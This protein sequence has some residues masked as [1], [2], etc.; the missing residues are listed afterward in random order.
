MRI[1]ALFS[2]VILVFIV[3]STITGYTGVSYRRGLHIHLEIKPVV[4]YS[5]GKAIISYKGL[6]DRVHQIYLP[7]SY[8]VP[9]IVFAIAL[10]PV[11]D[12]D[13]S[14]VY[15]NAV[16]LGVGGGLIKIPGPKPLCTINYVSYG[17]VERVAHHLEYTVLRWR[18]VSILLIKLYPHDIV[19]D[20][21]LRIYR[22]I[23]IW[24]DY[25][26][27][28]A[29]RIYLDSE[30][31]S[32]LNDIA[33]INLVDNI[34]INGDSDLILIITRP[35]FLDKLQPLVELREKQGF[36]VEVATVEDIVESG[37]SGRDIPE[38]M[39]NYVEQVYDESGGALKYLVLVGDVSGDKGYPN[40]PDDIGELEPWE[41]P[42]RYF[43]N[44][45]GTS[46]Y[47][48][49][50]YYT[51]SDWYYVTL[52]TTWDTNNN[53]IYG[54]PD[55][56]SDWAPEIAV[57]RLPFYSVDQLEDYVEALSNYSSLGIE[58]WL[59]TGSMLF[60]YNQDGWGDAGQ[61]GDTDS[62][63]VWA[64]VRYY[65]TV[66]GTRAVRLYEHYPV[67]TKI[68]SPDQY[69]GNI[70]TLTVSKTIY[71]LRPDIITWF[72][73][74]WPH[75]AWRVI[76][77]YDD[78]DGIPES[79][80]EIVRE[81]FLVTAN[82]TQQ[83]SRRAGII[84]AMSCLTA[85]YDANEELMD[86]WGMP[87]NMSLAE[88]YTATV[89]LWYMGWDRVTF[90]YIYTWSEQLNPDEWGLS[91]GL[92]YRAVKAM[93]RD[94]SA[95]KYDI[96]YSL[97]EAKIW[98]A[99]GG[100]SQSGRKVWWASTLFGDIS[101]LIGHANVYLDA[102]ITSNLTLRM[103]EKLNILVHMQTGRGEGLE[104]YTVKLLVNGVKVV[105]GVTNS[106]GYTVLSWVPN[107]PGRYT[108]TIK[109]DGT[110]ET[111][112]Y[113]LEY[114]VT[115]EANNM[116]VYPRQGPAN[117][118]IYLRANGYTPNSLVD[119][120]FNDTLVTTVYS[121]S[122]GD[123]DT[124]IRAPRLDPGYYVVQAVGREGGASRGFY[125]ITEPVVV[126]GLDDNILNITLE[127]LADDIYYIIY[128]DSI[129][130]AH[131]LTDTN[132]SARAIVVL[133]PLVTGIHTLN[134]VQDIITYIPLGY[135]LDYSQAVSIEV[136]ITTSMAT[137]ED[138]ASLKNYIDQKL[139]LTN[140]RI[141]ELN[142]TIARIAANMSGIE[143]KLS[144]LNT[145][146]ITALNNIRDN[147]S[148]IYVSIKEMY[149]II[150]TLL[151]R[152]NNMEQNIT[153]LSAT[154]TSLNASL[155]SLSNSI[156]G[157]RIELNKTVYDIYR[158]NNTLYN[159]VI[160][161]IKD[162]ETAID[163]ED[164]AITELRSLLNTLL[165]HV[166]R[167]G[168]NVTTLWEKARSI[169]DDV[170]EQNKAINNLLN[171]TNKIL[172]VLGV[173]GRE[174]D[175]RLRSINRNKIEVLDEKITSLESRANEV[176]RQLERISSDL[177]TASNVVSK[178]NRSMGSIDQLTKVSLALSIVALVVA[179]AGLVIG[180][181][182]R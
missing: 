34:T 19:S 46:G 17:S 6:P 44:P 74:G 33:Y 12:L 84:Y 113:K 109:H 121:N 29:T 144:L 120:Y 37:I 165:L 31:Y 35:M 134:I 36:R 161:K 58:S 176:N 13:V 47:S 63:A 85:A 2:L 117:T 75:I 90:G 76:W 94:T 125:T 124:C 14:A 25:T 38:K 155:L 106:T 10:S 130:V 51:P 92:V 81:P 147:I 83:T 79:N 53:E 156:D 111:M 115:V 146:T 99:S 97:I 141:E 137:L 55:D 179:V 145:S 42:T 101:Q 22:D 118:W 40:G 163:L 158:V 59:L 116:T 128:L 48:H 15:N 114:N 71:S 182:K 143:D 61:Q 138:I 8:G 112:P 89:G 73:H 104:G 152:T 173:P 4:K 180:S 127:G 82:L 148:S 86:M 153:M 164:S 68:A 28:R 50:G 3:A 78:G 142:R 170:G 45:D 7:N 172:D 122:Y 26:V 60:F 175:E 21:S 160:I 103:G 64:H 70:S 20:R 139:N 129:T 77:A 91:E 162:L 136:N 16:G 174:L 87:D 32:M 11:R 1:N 18:G 102:N 150:D 96:G 27:D 123:L 151:S 169:E 133:P 57:S 167:L 159:H 72:A 69:N 39:R 168:R 23:D 177:N 178:L 100:L 166:E 181:R 93:L 67:L 105:Q 149:S 88:K 154:L 108:L 119:I 131:I 65:S 80:G 66:S 110:D 9:A 62:E 132:G 126:V 95:S 5:G 98:L 41:V 43:Y 135:T 54:E 49:T 171:A 52:D 140:H 30:T 56:Y 24:I 157:L 107:E